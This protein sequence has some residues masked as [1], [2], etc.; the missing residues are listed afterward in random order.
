MSQV[1]NTIT[2]LRDLGLIV[3]DPRG[4]RRNKEVGAAFPGVGQFI[5]SPG[6]GIYR[7]SRNLFT[8]SIH[9]D[10][11]EDKVTAWDYDEPEHELNAQKVQLH[12]KLLKVLQ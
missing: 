3:E 6:G 9:I 8:L 1:Q 10:V 7:T 12:S 5:P 2:A 11:Q 4:G